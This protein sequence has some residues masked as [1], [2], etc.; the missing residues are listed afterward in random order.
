VR[1]LVDMNLSPEWCPLLAGQGWESVHWSA[2]G[3]PR[4]TDVVIMT[5]ARTHGYVVFTHDLDFGTLLA[6]SGARGPSVVQARTH[7]ITPSHLGPLLI[8]TLREH[9][10]ELDAGALIT[11]DEGRARVRILPI[12][13]RGD[14][15]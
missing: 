10:A 13:A 5:W 8:A 4:A 14:E 2:V 11:I 9:T 6:V 1:L 12:R 7:D 3:N 15:G